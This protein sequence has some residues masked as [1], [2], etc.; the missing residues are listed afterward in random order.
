MRENASWQERVFHVS[1][2][3]ELIKLSD[4]RIGKT[5][6]EMIDMH[7]VPALGVKLN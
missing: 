5:I 2:T 7:V 6:R 4:G 1:L 3:V